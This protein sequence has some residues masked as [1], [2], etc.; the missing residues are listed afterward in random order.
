MISG[1]PLLVA[2]AVALDRARAAVLSALGRSLAPWFRD[3]ERRVAW[4]GTLSVAFA[5]VLTLV[6]PGALL[7][8][9]PLVLGVPHLL[10]DGR[11][12]V[13]RRGLLARPWVLALVLGPAAATW[14]GGGAAVGLLALVGAG[15]SARASTRARCTVVALG[16]LAALAAGKLGRTA[17]VALAHLHNLVAMALWLGWRARRGHAHLAVVAAFVG[18][19]AAI[20]SGVLD[21]IAAGALLSSERVNELI[22]QLSVGNDPVL[23]VRMTLFFA[24]A[25]SV[26]YGVWL[27]LIPDED[28]ERTAPRPFARSLE[29]LA[30]DVSW[31]VVSLVA[32]LAAALLAWG[33]VDAH[34]ARDGYLRLAS[35]HGPMELG[36]FLLLLV[37]KP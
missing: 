35:F 5:L 2:P 16:V 20:L 17:D 23:A 4:T 37:E 11:Y 12:L 6:A 32:L 36:L 21:P 25:Q 22:P 30:R 7:A 24:F 15:L 13:I 1:P 18:A 29:A 26:H 14:F 31:P 8:W 27:R 10:A 34:A 3:R 19:S 33:A 28:R 9:G